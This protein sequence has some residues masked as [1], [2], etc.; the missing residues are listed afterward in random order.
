MDAND[1]F[2][3]GLFVVFMRVL[4]V[5]PSYYPIKGGAETLIRTLSIKL[6]QVGIHTRFYDI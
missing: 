4:M 6:N 1:E 3:Y 2:Q 5:T